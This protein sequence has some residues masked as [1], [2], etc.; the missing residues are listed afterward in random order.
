MG[1][2]DPSAKQKEDKET[3][4]TGEQAEMVSVPKSEWEQVQQAQNFASARTRHLETES[5]QASDRIRELEEEAATF[6]GEDAD[7]HKHIVEKNKQL[8]TRENALKDRELAAEKRDLASIAVQLAIRN[9]VDA[10]EFANCGTEREMLNKLLTISPKKEAPSSEQV[11]V[12]TGS[13]SKGGVGIARSDLNIN[14]MGKTTQEIM[15]Q[16]REILD[17]FTGK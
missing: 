4:M 16:G 8:L 14:T 9:G 5:K 6:E 11:L 15:N 17:K 12:G 10:Q 7:V 1:E 13:A 3:P 2:Q